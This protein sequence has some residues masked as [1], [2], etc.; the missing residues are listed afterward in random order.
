VQSATSEVNSLRRETLKVGAL[1]GGA[2][3]PAPVGSMTQPD[4]AGE[5]PTWDDKD[6]GPNIPGV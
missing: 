6:S 5:A 4:V 1:A 2:G 3:W